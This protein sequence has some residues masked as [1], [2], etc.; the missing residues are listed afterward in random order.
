MTEEQSPSP[1]TPDLPSA[2]PAEETSEGT[3]LAPHETPTARRRWRAWLLAAIPHVLTALIAVTLTL[4]IQR[5]LPQPE[6]AIAP[7]VRPTLAPTAVQ[8]TNAL[9][10]PTVQQPQPDQRVI[11][12]E[13]IDLTAR[14]DELWTSVYIARAAGQLGD[15]ENA[16]RTNDT[17]EVERVLVAVDASLALAYERSSDLNKG[18]IGEFRSQ[19]SQIHDDLYVRPEGLDQKLRLLRQRM[20]SLVE[21]P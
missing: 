8:P 18:P 12:Q 14:I 4:A 17:T 9:L 19:I 16:L 20:L 21:E 7:Y 13:I 2:A 1:E 6:P 5:M 11:G 10:T 3:S 15:A